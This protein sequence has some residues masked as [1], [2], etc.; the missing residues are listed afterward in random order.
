[1]I[2]YEIYCKIRAYHQEGKLTFKQIG[3]ELRLDPETVAKY[4][5]AATF[6]KRAGAKRTKRATSCPYRAAPS[7][8]PSASCPH[9]SSR[10]RRKMSGA[11]NESS[12]A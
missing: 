1:M 6:Q 10:R 9:A 3:S 2:G 12:S 7:R 11:T 8:R 4:A 5:R